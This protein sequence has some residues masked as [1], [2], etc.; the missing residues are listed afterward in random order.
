M[1]SQHYRIQYKKLMHLKITI[2]SM[3][4]FFLQMITLLHFY[5]EPYHAND[6]NTLSVC[7]KILLLFQLNYIHF[8]PVPLRSLQ[9]PLQGPKWTKDQ[10]AK[11]KSSVL[12]TDL[13]ISR[14]DLNIHFAPK[15]MQS[16][17][18]SVL[19]FTYYITDRIRR[20]ILT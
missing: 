6:A 4:W 20:P 7:N 3:Q 18:T 15:Q 9:V 1:H 10:M 14:T 8:G 11:T 13:T 19:I 12:R 17:V 2:I 16:V 5:H